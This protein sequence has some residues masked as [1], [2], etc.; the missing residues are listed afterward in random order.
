MLEPVL[1]GLGA[2]I[3]LPVFLPG[4]LGDKAGNGHIA[5]R[6]PEGVERA[7]ASRLR[8]VIAGAD[9]GGKAGRLRT[10]RAGGLFAVIEKGVAYALAAISGSRTLS[11]K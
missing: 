11:P 9:H 7:I 10:G 2:F 3:G 4:K 6:L 1:H 5:A 8:P